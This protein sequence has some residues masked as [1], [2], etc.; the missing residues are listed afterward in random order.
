MTLVPKKF[1]HFVASDPT[2]SGD[3]KLSSLVPKKFGHFVA[4]DPKLSAKLS[5]D[6]NLSSLVPEKFGHFV[7]SDPSSHGHFVASD[8]N[9]H[10]EVIL[11]DPSLMTTHTRNLVHDD[12][13]T[14]QRKNATR[15][16]SPFD[17][18][19]LRSGV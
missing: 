2:L 18:D 7:P 13:G 4:S 11:R 15:I 19:S 8:P 3:P 16:V 14:G 9:S 5:G 12:I 6:P 17:P 10:N 1:G